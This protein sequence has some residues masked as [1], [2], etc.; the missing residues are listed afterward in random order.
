MWVEGLELGVPV[1]CVHLRLDGQDPPLLVQK[2]PWLPFLF[3]TEASVLSNFEL[4]QRTLLRMTVNYG[5]ITSKVDTRPHGR[6]H[7][8]SFVFLRVHCGTVADHRQAYV[9]SRYGK[10]PYSPGWLHI[11]V[12]RD[13]RREPSST[14]ISVCLFLIAALAT[15]YYMRKPQAAAWKSEI[16][17][18]RRQKKRTNR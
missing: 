3:L 15:Y 6:L 2:T 11:H 14:G 7:S 1:F 10:Q 8:S 9:A 18:L 16:F 17:R 13:E 5:R 4:D 12:K